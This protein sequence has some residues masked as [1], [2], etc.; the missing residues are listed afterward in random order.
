MIFGLR[1]C[2]RASFYNF[3]LPY[4]LYSFENPQIRPPFHP[5]VTS[6]QR[7]V[8]GIVGMPVGGP[9]C[10][11]LRLVVRDA[12]VKIARGHLPHHHVASPCR[13]GAWLK[14]VTLPMNI[15][16]DNI[17][18]GHPYHLHAK[19]FKSVRFSLVVALICWTKANC[20]FPLPSSLESFPLD[21]SQEQCKISKGSYI[22]PLN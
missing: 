9:T 16:L 22:L 1:C 20:A 17:P 10:N 7:E 8:F 5:S 13:G 21:R 19:V 6:R 11:A 14:N 15:F 18:I 4:S 3:D 2:V 12:P